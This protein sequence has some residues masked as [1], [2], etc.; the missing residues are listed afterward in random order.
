MFITRKQLIDIIK[1][2][3][4]DDS[5]AGRTM[6]LSRETGLPPEKIKAVQDMHDDPNVDEDQLR[7][8]FEL[9]DMITTPGRMLP[10]IQTQYPEGIK[11]FD[12]YIKNNPDDVYWFRGGFS[13][14][15]DANQIV[16]NWFYLVEI[17]RGDNESFDFW[18]IDSS[19]EVQW[20]TNADPRSYSDFNKYLDMMYEASRRDGLEI[21]VKESYLGPWD[22]YNFYKGHKLPD[23]YGRDLDWFIDDVK[24]L[25]SELKILDY[26]PY[27]PDFTEYHVPVVKADK[28]SKVK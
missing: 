14:L 8:A 12:N 7:Q 3:Y 25:V 26:Y 4:R 9:E 24:K 23:G 21:I 10:L 16:D 19:P 2:V 27:A 17:T 15:E 20:M 13:G 11:G 28:R 1:E 22:Y 18:D 5:K 6:R